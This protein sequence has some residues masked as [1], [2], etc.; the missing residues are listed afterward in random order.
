MH[1]INPKSIVKLPMQNIWATDLDNRSLV[2]LRI[3]IRLLALQIDRMIVCTRHS[4]MSKQK[5]NLRVNIPLKNGYHCETELG[6]FS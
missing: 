4:L 2:V 3:K 1:K 6:Y 5:T